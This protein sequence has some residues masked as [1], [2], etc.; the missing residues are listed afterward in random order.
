MKNKEQWHI[1]HKEIWT[2]TRR[3]HFR[4]SEITTNGKDAVKYAQDRSS[5]GDEIVLHKEDGSIERKITIRNGI[6]K[7]I[8]RRIIKST[9][10]EQRGGRR[11][12]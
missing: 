6:N 5:P 4:A 12:R 1:W 8:I 11:W 2:I 3:G 7:N 9:C 10:R